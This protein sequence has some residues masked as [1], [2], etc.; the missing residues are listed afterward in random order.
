M[1]EPI[2]IRA[3]WSG[4]VLLEYENQL[5]DVCVISEVPEKLQSQLSEDIPNTFS[6]PA[7]ETYIGENKE[8]DIDLLGFVHFGTKTK[9][10]VIIFRHK[11][12]K[13][14]VGWLM[15]SRMDVLLEKGR[16]KSWMKNEDNDMRKKRNDSAKGRHQRQSK[17]DEVPI[18]SQAPKDHVYPRLPKTPDHH[19]RRSR[20]RER[21]YTTDSNSSS[22]DRSRTKRYESPESSY[23]S[24]SRS[25]KWQ[26][27]RDIKTA[28][29]NVRGSRYESR[30]RSGSPDLR[31][32]R[33][34]E[35]PEPRDLEGGEVLYGR[36]NWGVIRAI[37]VRGEAYD[38]ERVNDCPENC[39]A[40]KIDEKSFSPG[41]D[42]GFI[43]DHSKIAK[44]DTR[45]FNV[46]GCAAKWHGNPDTWIYVIIDIL[47]RTL[48][49][50][51]N[52]RRR[53]NGEKYQ[54]P[55]ICNLTTF[56][57]AVRE[58]KEELMKITKLLK[59]SLFYREAKPKDWLIVQHKINGSKAERKSPR[60]TKSSKGL[61]DRLDKLEE[62]IKGLAIRVG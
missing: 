15:K 53:D 31:R 61:E 3:V 23:S 54:G 17:D 50:R 36:Q 27:T 14:E 33:S 29:S 40:P 62:L 22:P 18:H 34:G 43:E 7:A 58:D 52:D 9:Y 19:E 59:K 25:L 12:D 46:V 38:I 10:N 42:K 44:L 11:V 21:S 26:R 45:K 30:E 60:K 4:W 28:N 37:V 6:L 56:K 8:K 2:R 57:I 39:R 48:R 49:D 32:P 16:V 13:S 51:L 20:N 47:D 41:G 55:L 5:F 24:D 1:S 35:T